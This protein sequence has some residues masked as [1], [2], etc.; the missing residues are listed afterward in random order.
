MYE[1]VKLNYY[2]ITF[3]VWWDLVIMLKEF[4]GSL[5]GSEIVG[6]QNI[7]RHLNDCALLVGWLVG[8]L[9]GWLC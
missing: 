9:G 8:W 4:T 7:C 3:G 2:R 5:K 6:H 1:N